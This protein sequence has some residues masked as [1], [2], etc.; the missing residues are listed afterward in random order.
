G[1]MYQFEISLAGAG[2]G[3]GFSTV[4]RDV[5]PMMATMPPPT[6]AIDPMVVNAMPIA[7]HIWPLACCA[8][9]CGEPIAF[10]SLLKKIGLPLPSIGLRLEKPTVSEK[11]DACDRPTAPKMMH[12]TPPPATPTPAQNIPPKPPDEPPPDDVVFRF[13]AVVLSFGS[14][15]LIGAAS[16][17]RLWPPPT[18]AALGCSPPSSDAST[19][20]TTCG[21]ALASIMMT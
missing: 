15:P 3:R 12:A 19:E 13:A 16:S 6:T 17:S 20:A 14:W 21:L 11:L 5:I 8:A 9:N 4:L 7:F 2:R 1:V 10:G 18:V